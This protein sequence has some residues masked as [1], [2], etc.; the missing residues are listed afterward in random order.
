MSVG[1]GKRRARIALFTPALNG[2]R[3]QRA[4]FSLASRRFDLVVYANQIPPALA[5]LAEWRRIPSARLTGNRSRAAWGTYFTAGAARRVAGRADLVHT[6][7]PF[8]LIPGKI[9]LATIG[10]CHAAYHDATGGRAEGNPALWRAARRFTLGLERWRY[11]NGGVRMLAAMSEGGKRD[12]ERHY[13][14]VPVVLTPRGV[15][16]ERFRPDPDSRRGTRRELGIA[17]D[18]IVIVHVAS[19]KRFKGLPILLEAMGLLRKRERR[20][21]L[22]LVAGRG[23]EWVIPRAEELGI[24]RWVR[25]LG[26][27]ADIE[28]IYRAADMLVLPTLY[29]TFCRVAHEAAAM[30]LPVIAPP[31]VGGIEELVGDNQAGLLAP[32]NPERVAEAIGQ[33][34]DDPGLRIRL[35]Q[36]GRRRSLERPPELFAERTVECY[37]RLLTESEL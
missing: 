33:L 9:D 14:G 12:L 27:R 4:L 18:E 6:W 26:H 15:D 5:G 17:S 34:A 10:F 31:G 7:A 30:E 36:E 25:T 22:L 16:T 21:P 32:R 20:V 2:D 11:G 13:P 19:A 24:A 29:E 3:T 1:G 28:R 35:G 8:P 37:E 23:H